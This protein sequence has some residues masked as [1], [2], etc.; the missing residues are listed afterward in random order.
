MAEAGDRHKATPPRV[1]VYS[2]TAGFRHNSIPY[3][4]RVITR[5]GRL[6][7]RWT[8]KVIEKPAALTARR[9]AAT[10]IVL[11]NSTT[12]AR[13][14]FTGAQERAYM[15][16]VRCGG[17]H[18]GV[19]ASTDSYRDWPGWAEL[20][21]AFFRTHPGTPGSASDDADPQYEGHGEPEARILVKARSTAL[22]SPWRGTGSFLLREEL[23]A[24]DRDPA[25]TIEDFRVLLAFG[26]YTDPG[27]AARWDSEFASEQPLAWTGSYRSLN[28]IYYTNLGHSTLTWYRP[29]FQDALI[30]AV[31][32][33]AGKRPS[34]TCLRKPSS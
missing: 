5:L 33:L 16:W 19:H 29:D 4:N 31:R 27:V 17:G 25:K 1:L 8:A 32:W 15:R 30:A 9:L 23:Y 6:S 22:T 18:T 20:T 21:G 12:G 10:D 34:R 2:G 28:R 7:G 24:F 26:G 3:A 14:P 13:S 11:W